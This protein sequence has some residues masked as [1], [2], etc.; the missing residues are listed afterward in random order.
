[1]LLDVSYRDLA[2]D[3]WTGKYP[4]PATSLEL[5]QSGS[6]QNETGWSDAKVDAMLTAANTAPSR[7]M[8]LKALEACE[9]LLLTGMPF[10][11]IYFHVYSSLV[12]PYVRGWA[13]NALNEHLFKYVW[14]D[15]N[16][17][18]Q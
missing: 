12:K 4:D 11:P 7:T 17:R 16:W 10:V 6:G 3:P 15:R 14:I 13:R 9:R 18:P 2:N 5:Y 1:M 8:R